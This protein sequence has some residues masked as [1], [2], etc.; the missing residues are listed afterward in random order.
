MKSDEAKDTGR[1]AGTYLRQ[2][3]DLVRG[4]HFAVS[5]TVHDAVG[6]VVGPSATP[7]RVFSD[8]ITSGV[9]ALTSRGVD[10]GARVVGAVAAH[11]MKDGDES[12]LSL[13]DG[14]AAHHALAIGLGLHGDTLLRESSSIAPAMQVRRSGSAVELTREGVATAYDQVSPDLVVFLHG[15]FE[16]EAAWRLARIKR[17][18]Y[19]ERLQADLGLTPVMVRYNTGLRISDNGRDLSSLLTELVAAWPMPVE[20]IV[21]IGHS[22]GGLVIHSALA[23]EPDPSW[24]ALVT[25]TVTLG[26]PHH[27]APIARGLFAAVERFGRRERSRFAAEFLRLRSVGIRDLAH[28]NIVAADWE[29]HDHDDPT[30]RRT[31]P[32]PR[33]DIRH[34]AVVGVTG[35]TLAAPVSELLGD[36]LVPVASA[37]HAELESVQRRFTHDGIAVV[38]GVTH[39][40]LLNNEET[41]AHLL[42]WLRPAPSDQPDA[43]GTSVV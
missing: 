16:T 8:T 2:V 15:L 34:H 31:H 21:L 42:R 40:G 1:A 12:R 3:T 43:V 22:M 35:P 25:E 19:A 38:R 10:A 14:P 20:R 29:S 36:L 23:S 28:G 18:S 41:Y 37:A 24:I 26:S 39:L 11:R 27:G 9:Y 7:I 30:D 4:A 32:G 13:H 5:D 17:R 6:A 33:A